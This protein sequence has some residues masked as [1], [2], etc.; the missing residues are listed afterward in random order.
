MIWYSP[1]KKK[2]I[3]IKPTVKEYSIHGLIHTNNYDL[4]T[5]SKEKRSKS[6]LR[7]RIIEP[8]GKKNVFEYFCPPITA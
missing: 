4:F 3:S 8:Y 2:K 1:R 6:N 7:Y 5:F